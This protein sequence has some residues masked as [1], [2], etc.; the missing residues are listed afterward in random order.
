VFQ[1]LYP[2]YVRGLAYLQSGDASAAAAQ[3]QKVLGRRGLVG[4]GVI[5]PLSR[6]QL[7]RVESAMDDT[8]AAISSY[9]TFFEL[10]R[11]ADADIPVYIAAKAEYEK[12]R[13]RRGPK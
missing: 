10:W 3:F 8:A 6:L 12:L 1:P 9:E 11:N 5:G 4:R 13:N 7:A 2:A